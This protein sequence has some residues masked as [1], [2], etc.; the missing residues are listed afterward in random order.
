MVN[1]PTVACRISS[2]LKWYKNYKN[3]L[4]LTKVMVKNK[5]SRFLWFTVYLCFVIV[6]FVDVSCSHIRSR[7]C[8]AQHGRIAGLLLCNVE[9]VH[10]WLLWCFLHLHYNLSTE[11]TN[12]PCYCSSGFFAG[13]FRF[14]FV[15][16]QSLVRSRATDQAGYS[17]VF[18]H[19]VHICISLS[20][21]YCKPLP[22]V[23]E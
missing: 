13:W 2:R 23:I 11:L 20:H 16:C 19:I 14:I 10:W 8:S 15:I 22:T 3:R 21:S 6:F 4:R 18:E 17:P 1:F 5:M 7:L 9:H 12:R